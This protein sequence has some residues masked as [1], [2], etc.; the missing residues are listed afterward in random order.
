LLPGYRLS[1][2]EESV[3]GS[4]NS[5]QGTR[6]TRRGRP[7]NGEDVRASERSFAAARHDAPTGAITLLV[8]HRFATV[9]MVDLVVVLDRGQIVEQG[10]HAELLQ[11]QGVYAELFR[12]QS[13]GYR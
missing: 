11:R 8:T 12:L 1:F 6:A 13:R 2:S 7:T 4:A 10:S 3:A 5:I 9:G